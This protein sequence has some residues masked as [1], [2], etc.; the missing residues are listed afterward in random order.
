MISDEVTSK[1]NLHHADALQQIFSNDMT[2]IKKTFQ[3][4]KY[5][6]IYTKK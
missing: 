4:I 1:T 6:K 2:K 5:G 3:I